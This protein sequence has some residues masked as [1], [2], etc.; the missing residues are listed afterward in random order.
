M[1]IQNKGNLIFSARKSYL[2]LIFKAAGLPFV[3]VYTDFNV[4]ANYDIT[5]KDKLFI[6]GL[7][8]INNVDRDQSSLENRI[9]NAGLLDNSQY[10]GI[11]GLNYRR[12]LAHGYLDATLGLNLFRYRFKQLDENEAVWFT[13]N[14][15]EWETSLKLQHY[16]IISQTIGVRSGI[17]VKSVRL[18]NTTVFADSIYD[19]SGNKL[20]VSTLTLPQVLESDTYS[21]K[22]AGFAEVDWSVHPKLDLNAGVRADYYDFIDHSWA[23]APRI[24]LKLRPDN[25]NSIRLS[26]GI[27]YQSPSY[28]WVSNPANKGL[29]PLRNIMSIFAWDRLLRNDLRMSLEMYYKKYDQLPTGTQPG[30]D[31]YIVI[32]NT[33]T[34]FGGREDDFQSFGYF[35]LEST[36]TGRAYGMELLFQKKFSEI[37]L[38]GLI[39]F[40]WGKSEVTAGNGKTYPGQ[41]D[42]RFITNI[43]GGYIFNAKWEIAAKFR[44]FTGVPHTPV[45]RPSANPVNPGYINNLPDEYLAAR[46]NPGHHL[47]IRVDRY[48][49]F[50]TWTLIVYMDIQNIYNFKIPQKPTY[51][52]WNDSI[53]TSSSIGI[54]PSIGISLEL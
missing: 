15:D 45:Y 44:Y 37:P 14:A 31:D 32:T 53:E 10:Q 5:E 3:P 48:F 11:S 19:R 12:L 28:V 23:V 34:G 46:T 8:A 22:K 36:A 30:V 39:T 27:Y 43:S 20:A 42:Q 50:Q 16:R 54:L 51:D 2:D 25:L 40:T 7:S 41:Y 24:S 18:N 21:G 47:D 52:F 35:P 38:Y 9:T 33:G 29:K 17:S 49:N 26:N 4:L 6:L 13:S 1:P